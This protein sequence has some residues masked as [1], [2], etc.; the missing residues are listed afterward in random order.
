MDKLPEIKEVRHRIPSFDI[1]RIILVMLVIN[2]HREHFTGA[3]ALFPHRF[4]WYAVPTFIILSFYLTSNF[5]LE[6]TPAFQS[7]VKRVKRFFIPFLFWS[8]LGFIVNPEAFNIKNVFVQLFTGGVVNVP[9]YYLLIMTVFIIFFWLLTF[10]PLKKRVV[11]MIV[12]MFGMFYL[13]YSDL[14]YNFFSKIDPAIMY[15]YGR[16]AELLPFAVTGLLLG[17]LANRKTKSIHMMLLT[18]LVGGLYF[19]SQA[20]KQPKGIDYSGTLLYFGSVFI[21]LYF[22]LIREFRLPERV[23]KIISTLGAYS[24]GVY[25]SHYLVFEVL[26]RYAPASKEINQAFPLLFLLIFTGISYGIVI[27][28]NKLTN[29]RFSFLFK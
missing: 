8:V 17:L 1:L 15:S 22:Y 6:H 20:T 16:I 5:Y 24:F 11:T 14:N 4:G 2:I 21:F 3:V 10:I 9:L 12:L 25:V 23:E 19:A 13:Q 29:H 28:L 27:G 18:G 7:V 26:F